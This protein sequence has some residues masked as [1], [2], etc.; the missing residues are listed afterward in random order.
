MRT[1]SAP[2]EPCIPSARSFLNGLVCLSLLMGLSIINLTEFALLGEKIGFS[3][4]A[5]INA[6][7]GPSGGVFGGLLGGLLEHWVAPQHLFLAFI[8]LFVL[9]VLT[10]PA[11]Q[12]T[13]NA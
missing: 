3:Q 6:L 2:L 1:R 5:S 13:S 7:A 4:A 10:R 12:G 11:E 9:L 8:P